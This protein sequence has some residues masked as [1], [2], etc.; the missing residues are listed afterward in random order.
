VYIEDKIPFLDGDC[1]KSKSV[2]KDKQDKATCLVQTAKAGR[3]KYAVKGS[4]LLDPEVEVQGGIYPS[5]R[6]SPIN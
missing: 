6:P 2:K 4:H 3:Y 1:K 5:P